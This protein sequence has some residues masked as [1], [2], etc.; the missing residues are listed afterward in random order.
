MSLFSGIYAQYYD[1]MYAR[2]KYKDEARFVLDL[3][4]QATRPIKNILSFGAGTLTYELLF[5]QKGYTVSGIDVSPEMVRLG[6]EKIT[7]KNK[8]SLSVG[9]MRSYKTDTKYDAVVSLFNVVSYCKNLS[10]LEAVF[11]SASKALASGGV[12]IF[13]CWNAEAVRNDPPQ[14][15]FAKFKKG[16]RELLR[17]TEAVVRRGDSKVKLYIELLEIESNTVCAR[18]SEV[19][20]VSAWDV[21]DIKQ[22]LK[23]T[24]LVWVSGY[25]GT[26]APE[27]ISNKRWAIT[28]I[29]R[30][31]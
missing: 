21:R 19:H 20:T 6:Q 3:F 13:D 7:E 28:I 2:K 1:E 8:L 11:R 16:E 14:S 27:K 26:V 10:E 22:L 4:Q 23:K 5:A 29:A 15:R 17:L 31:K 25:D 30:K 12:F 9:D 18:E 24:G